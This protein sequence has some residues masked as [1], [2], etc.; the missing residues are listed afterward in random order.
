MYAWHACA[1]DN[2]LPHILGAAIGLNQHV[3]AC[4]RSESVTNHRDAAEHVYMHVW[5]CCWLSLLPAPAETLPPST[6]TVRLP[7]CSI[8]ETARRMRSM[9]PMWVT[10]LRRLRAGVTKPPGGLAGRRGRRCCQ[11]GGNANARFQ[12]QYGF[13]IL[14]IQLK[15]SGMHSTAAR[16][17]Q[18][19]LPSPCLFASTQLPL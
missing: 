7:P 2:R 16:T 3:K 17:L 15:I 13:I 6:L 8:R 14:Y 12:N 10:A 5:C 1:S 9:P 11:A 18:K 19:L 4:V